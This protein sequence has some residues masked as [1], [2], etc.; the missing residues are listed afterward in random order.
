MCILIW[1]RIGREPGGGGT[2]TKRDLF[3]EV[4]LTE[5]TTEVTEKKERENLVDVN[6]KIGVVRVSVIGGSV[7]V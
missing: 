3:F 5:Y 7:E 4:F 1:S 6:L 2:E